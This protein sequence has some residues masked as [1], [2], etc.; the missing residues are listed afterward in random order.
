MGKKTSQDIR[1]EVVVLSMDEAKEVGIVIC[2][3]CGYPP[4]NHWSETETSMLDESACA[5]APCSGYE[6]T[7]TLGRKL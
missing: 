7:F 3:N 1:H 5:H 2:A 4:N 6:P